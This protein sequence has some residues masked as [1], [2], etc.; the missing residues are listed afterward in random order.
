VGDVAL[1]PIR[2]AGFY[3]AGEVTLA[4]NASDAVESDTAPVAELVL[5]GRALAPPDPPPTGRRP[6]APLSTWALLAAAALLLVEWVTT[7]RRWTV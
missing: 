4:A 3:G 5:G 2:R 1:V 7:H 6:I